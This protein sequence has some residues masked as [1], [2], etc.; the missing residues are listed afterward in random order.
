M[1]IVNALKR[2]FLTAQNAQFQ[3][4]HR[5]CL[6]RE[7]MLAVCQVCSHECS[8][9]SLVSAKSAANS[10]NSDQFVAQQHAETG[11][12]AFCQAIFPTHVSREFFEPAFAVLYDA[13]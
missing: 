12:K 1:M 11:E 13:G 5:E 8:A 2:G 6:R 3:R 7:G 9:Q 4:V 10:I